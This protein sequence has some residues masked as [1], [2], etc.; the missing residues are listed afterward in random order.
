M[1]SLLLGYDTQVQHDWQAKPLRTSCQALQVKDHRETGLVP[2]GQLGVQF[3]D[4]RY[5]LAQEA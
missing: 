1:G 3:P 4:S 2:A 5:C